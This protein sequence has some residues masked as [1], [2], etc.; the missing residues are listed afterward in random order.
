MNSLRTFIPTYLAVCVRVC[1]S[2]IGQIGDDL[3]GAGEFRMFV[4]DCELNAI[5]DEMKLK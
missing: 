4:C 3:R 1:S 2:A 5:L